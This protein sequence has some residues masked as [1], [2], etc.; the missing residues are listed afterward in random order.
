MFNFFKKKKQYPVFEALQAYNNKDSYFI[1]LAEW[2]WVNSGEIVVY[3]PYNPRLI[4]LDPWPQWVFVAANGQMTIAEY[5][6]FMADKYTG[7]IPPL[8]DKT[9]IDETENLCGYR[10]IGL[11]DERQRTKPEFELPKRDRK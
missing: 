5:V 9:I 11:V 10:I 7:S 8:L 2:D 3:D 6:Y 1:R 4:T